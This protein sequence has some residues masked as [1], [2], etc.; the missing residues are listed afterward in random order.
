[1]R[2]LDK[3]G[4]GVSGMGGLCGACGDKYEEMVDLRRRKETCFPA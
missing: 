1:M 3:V 4:L 2:G